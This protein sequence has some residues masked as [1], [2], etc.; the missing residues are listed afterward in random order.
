MYYDP[1]GYTETPLSDD[2][3]PPQGNIGGGDNDDGSAER[4]NQSGLNDIISL[5]QE[6]EITEDGRNIITH[7]DDG[8]TVIFRRDTGDY[9]HAISSQGYPAPVDHINI[10]IQVPT[11]R[12]GNKPKWDFH[13]ILDDLGDVIDTFITGPWSNK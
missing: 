1:S 11:P 9:A 6:G 10:E 12:G 3:C 4:D 8:T 5:I 7:L 13:I 2:G